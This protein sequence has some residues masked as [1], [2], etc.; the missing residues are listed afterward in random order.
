MLASP[1]DEEMVVIFWP[2]DSFVA[3]TFAPCNAAPVGSDT[4]I[5][6]LPVAT[7]TCEKRL[8][9]ITISNRRAHNEHRVF[10]LKD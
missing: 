7:V 9:G 6:I 5:S 10:L 3:D 1:E 4:A 2:V 8:D